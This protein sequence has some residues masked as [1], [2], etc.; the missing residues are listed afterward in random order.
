MPSGI[1]PALGCNPLTGCQSRDH[2]L[3]GKG[4]W[5]PKQTMGKKAQIGSV[6]GVLVGA[7]VGGRTGNPFYAAIGGVTGLLVGH[8]VG[9]TLDKV[10]QIHAALVLKNSLNHSSNGQTTK[11]SNPDNN[12]VITATPHTTVGKCRDFE[13]TIQVGNTLKVVKGTACKKNNEWLLKELYE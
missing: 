7:Y 5:A 13:T 6:T 3:P 11:W 9:A 12:V 4:V 2:Y 10:D 1:N 8:E